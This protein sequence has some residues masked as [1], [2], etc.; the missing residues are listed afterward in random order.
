MSLPTTRASSL[1]SLP[2]T[3][4]SSL[5]FSLLS[6]LASLPSMPSPCA[7]PVRVPKPIIGLSC[8]FCLSVPSLTLTLHQG[9]RRRGSERL[10]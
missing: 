10:R 1:H 3:L 8:V 6:S 4:V 5:P 2:F 7:S 9:G